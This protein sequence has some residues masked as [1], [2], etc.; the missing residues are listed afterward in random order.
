EEFDTSRIVIRQAL[1][2]LAN[3]GLVTIERNRGAFVKKYSFQEAMEIY[4]ALTLIEQGIAAQL[5]GSL[6]D[7]GWQMLRHHLEQQAEAVERKDNAAADELGAGFHSLLVS[8]TNNRLIQ[9]M[10]AQLVQRTHLLRSLHQSR[11]DYCILLEEHAK[12]VHLLE[13]G[14]LKQ[15]MDLIDKHHHHVVRGYV[16]DFSD[17]PEMSLQEALTPFLNDDEEETDPA[18]AA[19]T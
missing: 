14:R 19:M 5:A 10:H 13:R 15:V 2:R 6:D 8:L 16:M 18:M 11:F 12:I 4:D 1:I 7:A 9:D 17:H 3:D